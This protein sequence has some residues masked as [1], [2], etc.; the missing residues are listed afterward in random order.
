[1][2]E[3][4]VSWCCFVN[5][6]AER[7]SPHSHAELRLNHKQINV[8]ILTFKPNSGSFQIHN[9]IIFFC[10][11][12]VFPKPRSHFHKYKPKMAK[13]KRGRG[14]RQRRIS[15]RKQSHVRSF[16]QKSFYFSQADQIMTQ[17]CWFVSGC[18]FAQGIV[19][20]GLCKPA[21]LCHLRASVASLI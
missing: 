5:P 20:T 17:S 7:R 9:V 4:C 21:P 11:G 10:H 6:S 1:M 13:Q 18:L 16:S 14:Q 3:S 15:S 12:F 2:C 19:E 8:A